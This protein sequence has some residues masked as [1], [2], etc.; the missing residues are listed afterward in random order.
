MIFWWPSDDLVTFWWPSGD[1]LMTILLPSGGLLMTFWWPS[2][3]LLMTFHFR[4][5]KPGLRLAH[6]SLV[7]IFVYLLTTLHALVTHTHTH[8][9]V[10]TAGMCRSRAFRAFLETLKEL[11]VTNGILLDTTVSL[12]LIWDQLVQVNPDQAATSGSAERSR[13][14]SVLKRAFSL[15]TSRGRLLWMQKQVSLH[16]SLWEN[17]STSH[18]IYS[19]SKHCQH[20]F[21]S[22]SD[23]DVII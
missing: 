3:D 5:W 19:L 22:Q 8:C 4:G 23:H 7:H 14:G 21:M 10:L 13:L 11:H 9:Q 1:L 18:L 6:S 2:R 12:E 15:L 20:E 17:H 16:R